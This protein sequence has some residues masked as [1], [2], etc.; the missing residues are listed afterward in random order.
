MQV[1]GG[2]GGGWCATKAHVRGV[3]RCLLVGPALGRRRQ[4][5]QGNLSG[6]G[7]GFCGPRLAFAF[8]TTH[9]F[10]SLSVRLHLC[11]DASVVCGRVHVEG[12]CSIRIRG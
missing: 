7:S 3:V 6:G 2:G 10:V 9:L 8:A 4:R 12:G 5:R 11:E 1:V